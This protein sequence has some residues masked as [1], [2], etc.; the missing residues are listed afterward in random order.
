[1]TQEQQTRGRGRPSKFDRD[2]LVET[3]MNKFW[4]EGYNNVSLNEIA[5][6]AGLTRASLYHSFGSKDELFLLTLR[7]YAKGSPEHILHNMPEGM[8]VG[9]AL[10]QMFDEACK[11]RAADKKNRGCFFTNCVNELV[12]TDLPVKDELLK[13]MAQQKKLISS[14]IKKAISSGE[15]PAGADAKTLTNL[16]ISFIHGFGTFSKTGIKEKGMRALCESFLT[17]MGFKR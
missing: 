6:E 11:M 2:E 5:Q 12:A 17:Q 9:R 8:T 14:V 16:M 3:V 4:E 1:M 15:L 10:F 13:M 7:E